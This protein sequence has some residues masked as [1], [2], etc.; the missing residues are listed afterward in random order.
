MLWNLIV[1]SSDRICRR[2]FVDVRV[3]A[4]IISH[5]VSKFRLST[6]ALQNMKN[7]KLFSFSM[8][9]QYI[10][11]IKYRINSILKQNRKEEKKLNNRRDTVSYIF[12][13]KLTSYIPQCKS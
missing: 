13:R 1:T 12:L 8:H 6:K 3:V 11:K 4:K 5:E 2:W 10:I 7:G 9:M